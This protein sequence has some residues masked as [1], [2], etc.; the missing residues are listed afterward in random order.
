MSTLA[1]YVAILFA[2]DMVIYI[3]RWMVKANPKG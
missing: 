2:I 1:W 3:V